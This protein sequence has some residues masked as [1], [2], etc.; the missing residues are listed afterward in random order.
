VL[1]LNAY[2]ANNKRV[3]IGYTD[4]P[5]Y[6]NPN[7]P[8]FTRLILDFGKGLQYVVKG[9]WYGQQDLKCTKY[10]LS[11]PWREACFPG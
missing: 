11:A 6:T 8:N 10:P 3:G 4:D 1:Y 9:A 7:N 2:D 5:T